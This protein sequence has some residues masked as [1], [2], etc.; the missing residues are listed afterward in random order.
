VFERKYIHNNRRCA[1]KYG[2]R[3]QLVGVVEEISTGDMMCKVKVRIPSDSTLCSVMTVESLDDLGIRKGD[4][5]NVIAKAIN[6]LLV[7]E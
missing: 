6:I 4:T 1:M 7:K 3:N 2:A 5:V